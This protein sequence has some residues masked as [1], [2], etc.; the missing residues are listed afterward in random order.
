MPTNGDEHPHDHL[1]FNQRSLGIHEFYRRSPEELLKLKRSSF[2]PSD[3]LCGVI[4]LAELVRNASPSTQWMKTAYE[5]LCEFTN[6]P[7]THVGLYEASHLTYF[8]TSSK[9]RT[10]QPWSSEKSGFRLPPEQRK[11]QV[12][13]PSTVTIVLGRQVLHE[14]ASPRPSA[15]I[16]ASELSDL[17]DKGMG[18]SVLENLL[19]TRA[20]LVRLVGKESFAHMTLADKMTKSS[21]NDK[22]F[23]G[24]HTRPHARNALHTL[25]LRKQA[26][27]VLSAQPIIQA[28]DRDY[29]CF[30][31]GTVALS[32][33]FKHL[34]GVTFRPADVAHG[35]TWHTDVRK[36]E[37]VNEET[38]QRGATVLEWH[39]PLFCRGFTSF[40]EMA[41]AT[42]SMIGRTEYQNVSG[43]RCATDF[44]ELPSILMEHFLVLS[45]FD[46][47]N[48]SSVVQTGN[49]HEDACH[50]IDTHYQI[51]RAML[52]QAYHSPYVLENNFNS[53]VTFA[54]LQN[55]RGLIPY[56]SGTSYQTQFGHSFSYSQID[57]WKEKQATSTSGRLLHFG[58]GKDPW[59]M[60][61]SVFGAPQLASGDA[62]AMREGGKLRTK[63]ECRV[64]TERTSG[65]QKYK[66]QNG[67]AKRESNAGKQDWKQESKAAKQGRNA[68]KQARSTE[69]R[70]IGTKARKDTS[71]DL[72]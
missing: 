55:S 31:L 26:H 20:Q 1:L 57:H 27:L 33:L 48:A 71:I 53:T 9:W 35:E 22:R 2:K 45:L 36:L 30:T 68:G 29:Y 58:G 47:S 39:P 6:V 14:A 67:K 32:Q 50:H 42:H 54:Y 64:G 11:K 25:S 16:T 62:S 12:V 43:T 72:I 40:H 69:E 17:K 52:D 44:V 34:Y 15:T 3:L 49:H 63:L 8:G 28:W 60:V 38:E 19:K 70:S 13:S 10:K 18:I 46:Q 23:L 37:I 21:K 24:D 59:V 66:T 56:V 61:G 5:Q 65:E 7:N 4:D 51:L 41:H